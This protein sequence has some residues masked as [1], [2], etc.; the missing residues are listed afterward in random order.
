MAGLFQVGEGTGKYRPL[1]DNTPTESKIVS[2][3]VDAL[4]KT[5][6]DIIVIKTHG[7]A[8]QRAGIPDLYIAYQGI[9]LWI[10]MKRPGADTTA[11]QKDFLLKLIRQGVKAGTADSV[12]TAVNMVYTLLQAKNQPDYTLVGKTPE[13]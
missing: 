8:Y 1:S 4:R 13:S 12:D 10:E 11:L 5:F 9:S 6:P 3:T 7:G 2:K